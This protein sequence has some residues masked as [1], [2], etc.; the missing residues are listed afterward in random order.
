MIRPAESSRLRASFRDPAGSLIAYQG[1][2]LRVVNPSGAGDLTAFLASK[3]G[4]KLM[5]S[6]RVIPTRELTDNERATLL[7]DP[8]LRE[9][10]ALRGGQIILEHERVDFPSFPYEWTPE[11]L[12]AAAQLTLDLARELLADGLGLKDATPYNIL[13]RGPEP[14][15]IDVLSFERRQPGDATWLPY[16]QFVR[17]FLLP[18]LANR[19]FGLGLDQ[20]LTTRRDGLEPDELY[21]LSRPM[22]RLRPPFFGLVSM[23][24]WLG[25][26]A[27]R[28]ARPQSQTS[29]YEKKLGDPAR[30][31]YI[32]DNVLGGLERS[33]TRL[34]PLPG[35][36]SVWSDYMATNN[37]YTSGH[38]EA[39]QAFVAEALGQFPP[40]TVLDIGCNT[41]HFSALAA[42]GGAKVVALDY[43]PVVLGEV[44]RAAREHK[45]NILPLAVNITRPSPGT[46]WR[47][48]ECASFLERASGK[49]DAV[50]ML[51]V[52]HHMLVTERVPLPEILELAAELT[53]NLLIIEFVSPEDSMFRRLTRG[54]DELHRDL[55]AEAFEAA[56]ACHFEIVRSQQVEGATRRLYLLRKR[57]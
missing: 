12:H 16:A 53:T 18:L 5:S 6:G 19:T 21:R 10:Y 43:D 29:I 9:F 34:K 27:G 40:R 24:T 37:N 8:A 48:E 54:R 49:F 46:G 14:V 28:K 31:R 32:L 35:K 56:C 50:L 55:T 39:K 2:I 17:T 41:G 42:R 52:I 47:N 44:W 30:A 26:R 20:L 4:L 57:R 3:S 7:A 38:F 25:R 33:L 22:Q 36:R 51:A 45:L 23:P 15:F 11:M 13:F 1:R